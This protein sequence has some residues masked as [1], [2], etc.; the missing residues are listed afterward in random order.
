MDVLIL[1]ID[2]VLNT[3]TSL[4][5]LAQNEEWKALD[6]MSNE[7][8]SGMLLESKIALLN[9]LLERVSEEVKIVISSSWR[10]YLERDRLQEVLA[11][12]GFDYGDRI[13]DYTPYTFSGD[14][15]RE[16]FI[17]LEKED[18]ERY[19]ILDDLPA[20][21]STNPAFIRTSPDEGLIARDVDRAVEIL[22]GS[23]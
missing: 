2:G 1:D 17:Y 5:E 6:K 21:E 8:F 11:E 10:Q 12:A 19:V 22:V 7:W 9:N 16:V 23:K 13:V 15:R 14:R 18:I 3:K 20:A 4:A